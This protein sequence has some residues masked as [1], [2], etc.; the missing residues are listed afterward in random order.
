MK[1]IIAEKPAVAAVY[2]EVVG[3]KKQKGGYW[4][5]DDYL[6]TNGLGHLVELA[7]PKD[8]NPEWKAWNLDKLPMIPADY[9]LAVKESTK[10]QFLLVK[11][12][13][14]D[15][16][17]DSIICAT[18][19]D[20]EGENIFRHIKEMAG[21]QKPVERLWVSSMEE[22][23]I[24]EGLQHALPDSEYDNLADAAF[25]REVA[26]WVIG[27]NLTRLF[28]K[29]YSNGVLPVGRV[30]APVTALVVKREQEI[31]NFRPTPYWTLTADFDGL[32]LTHKCETEEE[33]K[34]L[35]QCK[36]QNA[37][38]TEVKSEPADDAP[39][40]LCTLTELSQLMNRY[41]G[42]TAAQTEAAMQSLYE[43]KLA[44][45]PRTESK[46]LTEGD[47][48]LADSILQTALRENFYKGE[49][50]FDVEK[51]IND[52]KVGG[53]PAL[54]PTMLGLQKWYECTTLEQ[55][56]IFILTFRL[57]EA[58]APPR[59]CTK[60]SI[61]ATMGGVE[62]SAT[63]TLVHSE[64]WHEVVAAKVLRLNLT[65]PKKTESSE[66][67]RE[68]NNGDSV[69]CVDIKAVKKMTQ[70]P[71][72]YTEGTLLAAMKKYN[73]GTAATRGSIINQLILTSKNVSGYLTYGTQAEGKKKS[74]DTKH[75]YP[76]Q[77]ACVMTSILPAELTDPQTTGRWEEQLADIQNGVGSAEQF[78]Q[79]IEHFVADVVKRE[80]Q[81]KSQQTIAVSSAEEIVCKCPKCSGNIIKRPVKGKKNAS[82]FKCTNSE[83]GLSLSSSVA[84]H[85]LTKPDIDALF[86]GK[87]TEFYVFKTQK[88]SFYGC[89]RLDLA[90]G[91]LKFEYDL[92]KCPRC[93]GVIRSFYFDKSDEKGREASKGFRCTNGKNGCKLKWFYNPFYGR[94]FPAS[95]IESM[96]VNGRT[97]VMNFKG[98]N[99][100]Y[101]A[102]VVLSEDAYQLEKG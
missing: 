61:K 15:S 85:I 5:S 51:V 38:I 99:G 25:C 78:V 82:Y 49:L 100:A 95:E 22:V 18:D 44:T 63:S 26:D 30:K 41:Y 77:K 20:R 52:K 34:R 17:V 11:Q 14:N 24:R 98:K 83:C 55:Q 65:A 94:E 40:K 10:R 76:S 54:M 23:A 8:I 58:T 75:L 92:C 89:M 64:G 32:M 67:K 66:W 3:A 19:P 13:M 2:A 39:P 81:S 70:P 56:I 90:E 91:K 87:R 7:E 97:S 37:V 27:M 69:T 43:K 33:M 9:P 16:R 21:C 79:S 59:C 101:R 62:W 86:A 1:L 50:T 93:D 6:V 72:R 31:A 73:L 96:F 35:S 53:H 48:G 88:M 42:A 47:R 74:E 36:G 4:Q 57:L 60:T 46:Y 12:L 80:K 45:Y 84:G 102:A 29:K 28:S 68:V 71:A